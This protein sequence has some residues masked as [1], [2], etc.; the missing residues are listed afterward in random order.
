M[1]K[2]ITVENF[3]SLKHLDYSCSKLN[4]LMGLNGAGKS[5]F[6]QFLLFLREM[7]RLPCNPEYE[8]KDSATTS[9]GNIDD[10]IYCYGGEKATIRFSIDF[11]SRREGSFKFLDLEDRGFDIIR[12]EPS[13]CVYDGSEAPRPYKESSYSVDRFIIPKDSVEQGKKRGFTVWD[14]GVLK[15]YYSSDEMKAARKFTKEYGEWGGDDE[16]RREEY[17]R[18]YHAPLEAKLKALEKE[19]SDRNLA[20]GSNAAYCDLWNYMTFIEAYRIKPQELHTIGSEKESEGGD[21][22]AR[23]FRDGNREIVGKMLRSPLCPEKEHLIDQVNAWL[24][25]VSPGARLEIEKKECADKE[26]FLQHV[27]FDNGKGYKFKPQNVGFGISYVLPVITTILNSKPDDIVIIENPEAHLHPRGQAEMGNLIARAAAYG[28]QVF[29]ETHSDHVINGIR[30]AVKRGIVKPEDVNIAFFERKGHE[31]IAEDGAKRKEY[32]AD[33]RN[34][35]ID[36]NGSLSEYP[37]DFM[38]EWNNQLMRLMKPR[39]K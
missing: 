3:K 36:G 9:L 15:E 37:E 17:L 28:V 13:E 33:V 35:K 2:R 10:A 19:T 25:V 29:V 8:I 39:K 23:L 12:G 6:V 22:V 26:I 27:A 32:Y 24:Q 16:R 30:V 5:S 7:G 4:L 11:T 18:E 34:I 21:I 20:N 38:D 31:I 14:A 1:L